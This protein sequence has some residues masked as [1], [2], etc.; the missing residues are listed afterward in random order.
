MRQ[1]P[2]GRVCIAVLGEE[3]VDR[4]AVFGD[5]PVERAPNALHL[6]RRLIKTPTHPHRALAPMEGGLQERTLFD[7]PALD[8]RVVDRHPALFHEFFHMP[9]AQGIRD[10][11]P[12]PHQN[13]VLWKMG[14]LETDRHGRAPS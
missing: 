4:F 2:L 7:D 9:I 14:P 10:I 8:G 5:R 12:D 1:K 11:P 3:K 13:D 6:D